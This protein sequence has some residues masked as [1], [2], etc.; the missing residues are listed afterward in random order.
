[1]I[2]KEKNILVG[3]TGSIAAYKTCEL[4]RQLRKKGAN[5]RVCMTS[6]AKEFVGELTFKALT[7]EEV[8]SDWKDGKTGLEHIFWARW[9][10]SFIIAPATAN[11]IA[12][13]R[14]GLADNFLTSVALA[15]EKPLVIAPAMNTK[16]YENPSTMENIEILK[17]RGHIFVDPSKGELACGE[18]GTGRLADTD[19]LETAILYS[20]LPKPLKNKKVLITAGGTREFLD[21]I[22]YISNASS[23]KMGYSLAKFAFAL[24]GDVILISA[25]TSLRKPYGVKLVSVVS[26]EEMYREVMN[27]LNDMDIIIMNAAVADFRPE[28]YSSKKLKKSTEKPV[29]NLKPN[30]DI[31][32]EIGKRKKK[33]QLLVGFAAESDNLIRNAEDKLRRKNLDV[34]VANQLEVFSREIHQGVIIFKD[35]KTVEI[36]PM[37]KEESAYFIL[38]KLFT[39]SS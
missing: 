14:Y 5:V 35:G 6:S 31:L 32:L 37:N 13:I 4:V 23:G 12:K 9:A 21:P 2:L 28:N 11:T 36:P 33:N 39:K 1:M 25:P 10:E 27:R 24:G 7:E 26:A 22:R 19:D 18:E 20:L 16:M 3:I 17:D 34:I 15:Y 29:I 30:P 38:S 8:L